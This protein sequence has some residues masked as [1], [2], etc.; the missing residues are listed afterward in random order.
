V[1]CCIPVEAEES[2]YKPIDELLK[3]RYGDV[4][5]ETGVRER[6]P[7]KRKRNPNPDTPVILKSKRSVKSPF[8][9][10][11]EAPMSRRSFGTYVKPEA[12]SFTSSSQEVA[13]GGDSVDENDVK[14]EDMS[15]SRSVQGA[16]AMEPNSGMT[17][18]ELVV[19]AVKVSLAFM[20]RKVLTQVV[21][22]YVSRA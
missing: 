17:Y 12:D 3:V 6:E 8:V 9:D 20:E 21:T 15:F 14:E 4:D 13:V 19:E 22:V 5:P 16:D 10:Y 7:K 1:F 2:S 18:L 11:V